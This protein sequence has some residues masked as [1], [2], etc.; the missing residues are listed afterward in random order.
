[1]A[2]VS[3]TGGRRWITS[4]HVVNGTGGDDSAFSFTHDWLFPHEIL[5]FL[6]L[7]EWADLPNPT[8]FAHPLMHTPLAVFPPATLPWP[9]APLLEEAIAKFRRDIPAHN[10]F[11]HVP[12]QAG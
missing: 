6:R 2:C 1:M 3:P 9:E 8:R 12:A 5:A 4:T 11:D 7:R 10:H